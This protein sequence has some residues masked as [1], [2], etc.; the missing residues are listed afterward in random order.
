M[1]GLKKARRD[2]QE[3]PIALDDEMFRV[4]PEA[5]EETAADSRDEPRAGR[6]GDRDGDLDGLDL[7]DDD[8]LLFP[9][10]KPARSGKRLWVILAA[11]V[12]LAVV[13]WAAWLALSPVPPTSDGSGEMMATL[14]VPQST[15]VPDL[16]LVRADEESYKV[17]PDD[18]G[19]LQVENKDKLVYGRLGDSAGVQDPPA[20]EQLLPGP[21]RPVAPPVRARA[22]EPPA[23][24][25][26]PAPESPSSEPPASEPPASESEGAVS[27]APAIP[28]LPAATPNGGTGTAE[29]PATAARA[30]ET[31]TGPAVPS[32][33][34]VR[35]APPV[36]ATAPPSSPPTESAAPPENVT[37]AVETGAQVQLAAFRARI[38]AER[39]W[40]SLIE[41]HP[42]LLGRVPHVI[43]FADLGDRGAFYRL[44]AGP[45]ADPKEA[46]DLCKAL[47]QRDVECLI[48]RD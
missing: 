48:V 30:P 29:E 28:G 1:S 36:T 37:A 9:E 44:R 21:A 32:V 11:L 16:P 5:S 14:Q 8:G 46:E 27:E 34:S 4:L 20:V 33:P 12:T 10:P 19:G 22:P 23:A 35:P 7:D 38:L 39:Q 6:R 24:T 17:Q 2:G 47:K 15:P 13:G 43:V 42:D 45:F 18:P 40:S 26:P 31:T 25:E 3:E 41:K